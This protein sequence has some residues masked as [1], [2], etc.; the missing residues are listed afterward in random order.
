MN[1]DKVLQQHNYKLPIVYHVLPIPDVQL[2]WLG[3]VLHYIDTHSSERLVLHDV[4]IASNGAITSTELGR[5]LSLIC[6]RK[7][8][9]KPLT[10]GQDKKQYRYWEA[11]KVKK[12]LQLL[13]VKPIEKMGIFP[14]KSVYRTTNSEQDSIPYRSPVVDCGS[15]SRESLLPT[16]HY[17]EIE[18]IGD[19]WSLKYNYDFRFSY[20]LMRQLLSQ[21]IPTPT[22]KKNKDIKGKIIN[23]PIASKNTEARYK[24]IVTSIMFFDRPNLLESLKK[25]KNLFIICYFYFFI[26]NLKSSGVPKSFQYS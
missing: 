9:S 18:I 11:N 1:Q 20:S 5:L 4:E 21:S 26:Y 14:I 22:P 3:F 24:E 16:Y 12:L 10:K 2:E 23:M 7:L 17:K 25:L 8:K 19:M 13:E 6:G 15:Y